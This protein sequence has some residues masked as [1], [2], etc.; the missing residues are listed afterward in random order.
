MRDR[1]REAQVGG[2]RREV[3]VERMVEKWKVRRIEEKRR[4]L[5]QVERDV[6]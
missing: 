5:R 4:G 6:C 3:T 1:R 2:I